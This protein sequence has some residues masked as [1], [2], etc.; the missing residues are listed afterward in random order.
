MKNFSESNLL[1]Y[2]RRQLKM[3]FEKLI[4]NS[5]KYRDPEKP[6]VIRIKTRQIKGHTTLIFSDNGLGFDSIKYR[7]EIFKPYFRVH[8]HTSGTGL[9]L[10]IVKMIVDYHKG[11]IR[12]ESEPKKGATFAIRLS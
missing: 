5:I 9:G 3:I 8:S 7:E 10:Y 6:L 1:E 12:V 11:G 2:P 4:S